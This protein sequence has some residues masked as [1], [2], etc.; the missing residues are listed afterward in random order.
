MESTTH[1]RDQFWRKRPPTMVHLHA[2]HTLQ[3]TWTI[4]HCL[5]MVHNLD[6]Y[7]PKLKNTY[8]EHDC[9]LKISRLAFKYGLLRNWL[10]TE[11]GCRRC[12][13]YLQIRSGSTTPILGNNDQL[14]YTSLIQYLSGALQFDDFWSRIVYKCRI[15]MR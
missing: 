5:I 12:R 6:M 2:R 9:R 15:F 1:S 10:M 14:S 8:S 3:P 4:V 7:R 11:T 13:T